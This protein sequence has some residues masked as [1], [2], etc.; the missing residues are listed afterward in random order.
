MC[1]AL[2]VFAL[3]AAGGGGKGGRGGGFGGYGKKI[4]Y[5]TRVVPV[6]QYITR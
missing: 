3:V 6:P 4:I 2:G 5:N 1:Q